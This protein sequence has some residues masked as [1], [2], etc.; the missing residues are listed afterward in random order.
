MTP[1]V[2]DVA[3]TVTSI[4]SPVLTVMDKVLASYQ[5]TGNAS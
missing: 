3:V 4:Q 1:D 5:G 2:V